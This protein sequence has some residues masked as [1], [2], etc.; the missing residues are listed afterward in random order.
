MWDISSDIITALSTAAHNGANITV[1]MPWSERSSDTSGAATLTAAGARV[2]WEYTTA[3]APATATSTTGYE[4][5]PMDIH[6]KFAL[7]DGVAYMDGHNWFTTDVVMQDG[8]AGD[9]AA[10]QADLENF[11]AAP[12]GNSTFTTDKQLSLKNES[13]Y[14]QSV[15]PTLTSSANEYDFI[16]ESFNPNPSGGEYNDDVYDG[17][18]QI[19]ALPAHVTMH[20]VVEDFSTDSNAAQSA[21]QNLM[22]LDPNASVRSTSSGQEKISMVRSAVGGMPTS[23]WFGSSNSTTTDL[24][25]WGMNITNSTMLSALQSYFDPVFN[26]ASAIP[27]APAGTAAAP[28]SSVHP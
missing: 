8:I 3:S 20:V 27:S 25:D 4:S 5:A 26:S 14:L 16:T 24:F 12:P 18:C 1:I 13:A 17:M 15:I 7:V 23:A 6:A 21:L 19:A 22:L 11:P 28:C 2:K 9:F 10:I